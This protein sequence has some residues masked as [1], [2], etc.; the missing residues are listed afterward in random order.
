MALPP[1]DEVVVSVPRAAVDVGSN[2]VR[3]LVA[4]AAG[5][6]ITR[7]MTVT[8]L[9]AGVDR[10]GRLDDLALERTVA[11]IA[12][13]RDRWRSHGVTDRVRITAT[14]AVRDAVD[15][16]RFFTAVLAATGVEAELLSGEDEATLSFDGASGAVEV[17]APTA[18][19]DIGGGSTELIVGTADGEVGG[20]VSLQLG[21][22]RLTERDLDDDPPSSGQLAAARATIEAQL[23][24][25]DEVLAEQGV[26][27]AD[28]SSLIAVAGTATT[29]GALDLQLDAYLEEQI[30]GHHLAAASLHRLATDLAAM[31]S[32][33]RATFGPMQPGREGVIHAGAMILSAIVRRYDV[34]EVVISESDSL[35]GLVA[36]LA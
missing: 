20:S 23:D 22:V 11:T 16:D 8:R 2:S 7:E 31:T 6:R 29:L 36:S 15:R 13:Y 9:A 27:V 21:C 17:D 3:L 35:D 18:V 4:D 32:A 14:S 34:P 26:A 25:A 28:A 24:R 12:G 1:N 19:V 5:V 30:H 10:T 33:R